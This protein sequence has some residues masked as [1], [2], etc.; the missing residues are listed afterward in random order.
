[1]TTWQELNATMTHTEAGVQQ[2]A[3]EVNAEKLQKL[4]QSLNKI[5]QNTLLN[6]KMSM[7]EKNNFCKVINQARAK[8]RNV[9]GLSEKARKPTVS[10]DT[11]SEN[12]QPEWVTMRNKLRAIANFRM[13]K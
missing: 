9:Q 1:M 12:T 5:E 4:K 7:S 11:S 3:S 10:A 2:E 13:S 6:Q 8:L